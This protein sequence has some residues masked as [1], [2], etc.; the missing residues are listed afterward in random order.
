MPKK[1]E[2]EEKTTEKKHYVKEKLAVSLLLLS[3]LTLVEVYLIVHAPNQ[4]IG[5][6]GIGLVMLA[7][8]YFILSVL[9][10]WRQE[11][12]MQ[13]RERCDDIYK[14]VKAAYLVIRKSFNDMEDAVSGLSKQTMRQSGEIIK[15]QKAIGKVT[16]NR[17]KENAE[18]LMNSNDMMSNQ[19]NDFLERFYTVFQILV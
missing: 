2:E 8:G 1:R 7:V 12:H 10:R 5:V 19:F 6:G 17:N 13:L 18:A 4:L 9:Y 11:Q 15:M 3:V 14:S 16:I